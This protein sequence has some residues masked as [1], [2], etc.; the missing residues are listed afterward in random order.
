VRSIV[1]ISLVVVIC[2]LSQIA[3]AQQG[4]APSAAPSP[5]PSATPG[6]PTVGV[7]GLPSSGGI[8]TVSPGAPSQTGSPTIWGES[9]RGGGDSGPAAVSGGDMLPSSGD[10]SLYGGRG[11]AGRV[12]AYHEVKKGDT[13]WDICDHYYADPWS[14]PQVWAYN[15][16]VTNPHWIYP[17]DRVRL[18]GAPTFSGR[19]MR[20]RSEA[21]RVRGGGGG[22]Q[23]PVVQL[24]QNGFVDPKEL[25]RTGSVSGAPV[26]KLLLSERDEI[27]VESNDKFKPQRGQYY[28]VYRVRQELDADGKKVGYLVEILG[29]VQVKSVNDKGVG[30]A[31]ITESINPIE[32]GDRIG[33]LRRRLARVPVQAAGQTVEG[34][35]LATMR[36]KKYVGSE[37]LVFVSQGKNQGVRDGNRFLVVRRGDAYKRLI[38]EQDDENTNYPLETIAEITI[39]DAK[40]DSSVGLVTR[41]TKEIKI[42]DKVRMRQGY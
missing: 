33:P 12:P 25:E 32:R 9:S 16:Q 4:G 31:L 37:D 35:V 39:V 38:Q 28:S 26:E 29:T 21:L 8:P 42:G 20:T 7:P 14:W 27:Y 30:T 41:S 13:L 23:T 19:S 10:P 22:Y 6:S 2:G 17:G 1:R 34:T 3:A 15:K 11:P 24:R 18:L 5:A 36:D 40:D